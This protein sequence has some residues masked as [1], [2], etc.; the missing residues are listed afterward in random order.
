MIHLRI[1]VPEAQSEAALE[2]LEEA[3]S[4]CNL[5]YLEGVARRPE[6]DVI[7]CDVAREDTS[8]IVADLRELDIDRNGSIALEEVD[9][10]ISAVAD[11]AARTGHGTTDPVVWEEVA[12]QTSEGVELSNT[13]ILYMVLAMLIAAVGIYFDQPILIIGAMVVGPEFGPIAAS[14]VAIVQRE[15]ALARR[16]AAALLVGFPTGIVVTFIA[17]LLLD[18]AGELP[19]SIDFDDQTLTRYISNPDFFSFYVALIA[20]VV[21]I[22]SLTSAKSSV[23]VGVLISVATIPA[24]ANIGVAA[25]YGDWATVGGAATQLAINLGAI[26][27]GGLLT[28]FIQRRFYISR[29]RKHLSDRSRAHA[30][31]PVGRSRR[32]HSG[33]DERLDSR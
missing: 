14:C 4:V 5:I 24:A 3:P 21:G 27:A 10:E 12:K 1:V 15:P 17:T 22:L 7:L 16:S 18:L 23:L 13:F 25:A 26:F 31:L 33:H 20:G 32:A 29:R 11:A 8:L 28:F 9:S 30:G 6:G 2:L 19:A